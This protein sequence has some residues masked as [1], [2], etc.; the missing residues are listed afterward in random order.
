MSV[1]AK[2]K[3]QKDKIAAKAANDSK[4]RGTL[5]DKALG[6]F[7]IIKGMDKHIN[8]LPQMMGKSHISQIF[9]VG[10]LPYEGRAA[11]GVHVSMNLRAKGENRHVSADLKEVLLDLKK[12]L[13]NAQLQQQIIVRRTMQPMAVDQTPYFKAV[14]EPMLK[15]FQ[16]SDWSQWLPTLNVGFYF[17]ELEI[18]PALDSFL[19]ELPMG[20][21]TVQV[22]GALGRLK[23]RL[24]GDIDTFGSQSNTSAGYLMTAQDCVAHTD[25]TEDLMQDIVPASGGFERLRKEV[26]LGVQRSKEDAIINGDDTIATSVQGDGH[27]DSDIA[28][29]PATEFNK[30]FKGLRKRALAAGNIYD[31]EGAGFDLS[32]YNG[33]FT[34]L[35]KFAKEK[36]DLLTIIGPTVGNRI[37]F[38]NVPE[39]LTADKFGLNNMTLATGDL[40]KVYGIQQYESEWV[41]EDVNASGVYAASQEFTTMI[42]LK[43]SRFAVGVRSPIKIWATPSLAN[44]D[45]MLLTAK[46][47]FTFGGVPQSAEETSVAIATGIALT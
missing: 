3:A 45:K 7:N 37:V 34:K 12:H 25:I 32:T 38:G 18:A 11:H 13:H 26:A 33:L 9:G 44:M 1:A 20:S 2:L 40:P 43:K 42:A 28:A 24:Q 46:E 29:L 31:N 5:V 4:E 15:A 47:R 14:V 39:I 27:M 17:E 10:E 22:P 16:L 23:G 41:R 30:A 21:K 19:P 36:G 6:G 35:G 8:A